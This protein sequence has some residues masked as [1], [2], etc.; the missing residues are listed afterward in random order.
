MADAGE[1]LYGKGKTL[2]LI[3]IRHGSTNLNSEDTSV[4]RLRGWKDIPLNDEGKTEAMRTALKL[5]KDPP[6]ALVS[7]DMQRAHDT[8]KIISKATHS[9]L[10]WVT[11][12]FRPWDVGK[13]A[14]MVT[15]EAIPKLEEYINNPDKVVPEGESF[16]S[17][18]TRFLG[19]I[20]QLVREYDEVGLVSH[21]RGD[22]LLHAWEEKGFSPEGE[23]CTETFAKKGESP[24]H[25]EL[26]EIP[27]SAA[28]SAAKALRGSKRE[29]A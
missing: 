3:L 17:F 16:N 20:A 15:R 9:P 27:A 22:R 11:K 12:D 28:M 1:K 26:M 4:D 21:Y 5:R 29:A 25:A 23:I 10:E 19:G 6:P 2:R 7:S 13:F 18:R 24:G 14:G 8:A